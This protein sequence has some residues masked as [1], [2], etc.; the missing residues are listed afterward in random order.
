M[1]IDFIIKGS[2]DT[3]EYKDLLV[4]KEIFENTISNDVSGRILLISNATLFGQ[5]VKDIDIIAIGM[6]NEFRLEVKSRAKYHENGV[7]VYDEEIKKRSVFCNDFCFVFETKKHRAEDIQI[8][9]LNLLVKYGERF[10]DATTQ[11]ERQKY[12]LKKYFEERLNF[13]PYICNFIWLRGVEWDSIKEL[14]SNDISVFTSHNYLPNTFKA[15][16]LFQLA[17]VQNFPYISFDRNEMR[18]KNYSILSSFKKDNKI[19]IEGIANA[20]DLFEKAK[21]GMGQLTRKKLEL[22]TK[23]FMD[24]PKYVQAIGSKLLINS[25]KAGTGKTIRLLRIAFDAALNKGARCLILTYNLAL[26]SDIR[27]T[28]AL[29]EVPDDV[30][31]YTV[32][33]STLHKFMY[34]VFFA[35]NI[36]VT[37]RELENG[38]IVTFVESY[39]A[40]YNEYIERLNN[41]IKQAIDKGESINNALK[42]SHDTIAWDYV[43]ID[44]AQDWGEAEKEVILLIF[45]K[46]RTIIA[47]GID[48]F[49]RSQIKCNWTRGLKLNS[50]FI[51]SH[52]NQGLRQKVNIFTFIN[53]FA[54]KI[55]INWSIDPKDDLVGGKIIICAKEYDFSFHKKLTDECKAQGNKEYEMMFLVPPRLVET[56]KDG[57]DENTPFWKSRDKRRFK[58]AKLFQQNG[59]NIWDGTRSDLRSEYPTE[60]NQHRLFQYDSCRGLEGWTVI[61]LEF[62]QFIRY[63]FD[64]FEKEENPYELALESDEEKRERFVNLWSLIP[65]TRAIDTLVINLKDKQGRIYGIFRELYEENPDYVTWLD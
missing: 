3:D 8:N 62:D 46:N 55:N 30:D 9:G 13:S 32:H 48:Q 34:E 57:A 22:I 64:T 40:N 35:F 41:K 12:S 26:V 4:L 42:Q 53:K 6:F 2:K 11:S 44:E 33:I 36:G 23:G 54:E 47:D 63:K 31:S 52:V 45:G 20:F 21:S 60:L 1:P 61:C 15:P 25:G 7:L 50:D 56:Y 58:D 65:L 39:L 18:L 38:K 49:V 5:E 28:I 27:R 51:K 14:I 24:D 17:C 19:G 59:I 43:F 29:A 37:H 16:F 10:S